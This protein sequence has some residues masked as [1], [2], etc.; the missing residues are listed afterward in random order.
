LPFWRWKQYR[1]YVDWRLGLKAPDDEEW[2][3]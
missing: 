2:D 3:E 1:T